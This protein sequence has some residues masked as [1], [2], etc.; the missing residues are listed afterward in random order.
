M[1][2]L[3]PGAKSLMT[4]ALCDLHMPFHS[5][6]CRTMKQVYL[7]SLKSLCGNLVWDVAMVELPSQ[8]KIQDG[9]HTMWPT[10]CFTHTHGESWDK[11]TS[12]VWSCCVKSSLSYGNGWVQKSTQDGHYTMWPTL[13]FH[14]CM[15]RTVT[16]VY[17]PGKFEVPAQSHWLS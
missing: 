17:S 14:S 1:V 12:P 5:W 15:C 6:I 2:E 11:F 16:Q 4:T 3:T 7:V 8:Y 13:P 9:N 10:C